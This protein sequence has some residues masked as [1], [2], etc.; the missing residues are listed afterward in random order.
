MSGD[1]IHHA[2]ATNRKAVAIT[3]DDGP[4]P[5]YTPAILDILRD[6]GAKAT[7]FMIGSQIDRFPDI[8]RTVHA[9]G[10]EIGNHTY[11][12]PYLTRLDEESC[13][14]ELLR[15]HKLIE[16]LAGQPP[17]SFRPPYFD[18]DGRV[19]DIAANLGYSVIGAVNGAARDW[20]QPGVRHIVESSRASV[21]PGCV[22]LFHDGFG[23][24][25]QTVEAVRQL[26]TELAAEGYELV[27]VSEL[28]HPHR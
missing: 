6:A 26:V 18:C 25:S 5:V 21:K 14:S 22:L 24:R 27:T 11:T 3:F 4:N 2:F 8:A 16:A 13:R 1:T 23:D 15:T 20:E 19:A 28:A 10:H 7:F 12:H 17:R 9:E